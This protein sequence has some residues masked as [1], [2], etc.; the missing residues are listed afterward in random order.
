MECLVLVVE[1]ME[2]VQAVSYKELQCRCIQFRGDPEA[3]IAGNVTQ[4]PSI[5]TVEALLHKP[6][7][8]TTQTTCDDTFFESRNR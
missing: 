2:D 3:W 1:L 5:Q 4:P 6:Q 8:L 7:N